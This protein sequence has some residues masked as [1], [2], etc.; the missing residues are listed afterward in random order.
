MHLILLYIKL[1]KHRRGIF[2]VACCLNIFIA[3]EHVCV[4]LLSQE[5]SH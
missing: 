1:H 4:G 2:D 5:I 3:Q